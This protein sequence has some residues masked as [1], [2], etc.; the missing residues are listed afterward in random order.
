M[1]PARYLDISLSLFRRLV[2]EEILPR[3]R[4]VFG[5]SCVRWRRVDLDGAIARDWGE[6]TLSSADDGSEWL[7]TL[8]EKNNVAV[9]Q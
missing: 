6:L 8:N 2:E 3:G 4:E 1:K 9:S 7:R 5:S